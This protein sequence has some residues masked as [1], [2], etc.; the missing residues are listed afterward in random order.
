LKLCNSIGAKIKE[1]GE[2]H[3]S[4]ELVSN[5]TDPTF[6]VYEDQENVLKL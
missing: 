5:L 4:A 1:S 2:V 3:W 6:S